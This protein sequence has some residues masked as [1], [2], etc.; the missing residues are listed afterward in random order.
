MVRSRERPVSAVEHDIEEV[1]ISHRSKATST[2]PVRHDRLIQEQR[3]DPYAERAKPREPSACP[4]CGAIFHDGRWRWGTAPAN[5]HAHLCPACRRVRDKFP[6]GVVLIGGDFDT[7][8][9]D[10]YLRIVEHEACA[11]AAGH[12]I[13]R[14][15][16]RPLRRQRPGRLMLG[17]DGRRCSMVMRWLQPSPKSYR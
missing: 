10:E 7:A 12:P 1:I 3:D 9:K 14:V 5:A 16:A 2:H 4:E 11:E 13:E 17:V 6:A 8:E 15:I